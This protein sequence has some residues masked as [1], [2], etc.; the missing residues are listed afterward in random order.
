MMK[1]AKIFLLAALVLSGCSKNLL[2]TGNTGLSDNQ[3]GFAPGVDPFPQKFL[4]TQATPGNQKVIL[5]WNSSV[6]AS[7]YDL[8]YR[9]SGTK[10]YTIIENVNSPY[11][12]TN[13]TNNKIYEFIVHASNIQGTRDS[14]VVQAT[15]RIGS[16][17][18]VEM[19]SASVLNK[20]TASGKYLVQGSLASPTD[21]LVVKTARGFEVQLNIQGQISSGK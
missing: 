5:N 9:I 19:V 3:G 14:G 17:P 1:T 11:I 10:D 18:V 4:I 12:V 6:S 13:L 21:K 7:K 15:P 20:P 2:D 16:G 8:L